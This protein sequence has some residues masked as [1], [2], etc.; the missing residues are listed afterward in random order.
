[1]C[2]WWG[3]ARGRGSGVTTSL[4]FGALCNQGRMA[5]RTGRCHCLETLLQCRRRSSPANSAPRPAGSLAPSS[6]LAIF[7]LWRLNSGSADERAGGHKN[8][9][10]QIGIPQMQKGVGVL[11]LGTRVGLGR[12]PRLRIVMVWGVTCP[13]VN[14]GACG[15]AC[16][17]PRSFSRRA[18]P[19]RPPHDRP[20]RHSYA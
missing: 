4:V 19:H 11:S 10:S 5:N 16:S 18:R 7:S 15:P 1:M 3:V 9:R 8:E 2:V 12:V 20:V 17:P 6:L 14:P 13:R